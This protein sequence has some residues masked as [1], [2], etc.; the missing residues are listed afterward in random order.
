MTIRGFHA[1]HLAWYAE[2][3][4]ITL[5]EINFGYYEPDPYVSTDGEYGEMGMRWYELGGLY[6]RLEVFGESWPVLLACT[7][8][9]EAI[10]EEDRLTADQFT[11]ILKRLGFEDLTAYECPYAYEKETP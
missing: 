1:F 9:L 5:P 3:N 11:D 8:V 4:G 7:D 6:P 10:K 2:A